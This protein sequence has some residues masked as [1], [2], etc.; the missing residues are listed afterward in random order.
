MNTFNYFY[1]SAITS[2]SSSSGST[3]LT[4]LDIMIQNYWI[5]VN[6]LEYME[7]ILDKVKLDC[8]LVYFKHEK[9]YGVKGYP[10]TK[11]SKKFYVLLPPLRFHRI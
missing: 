2:S 1:I 9:G 6:K 5:D 7:Y 4:P 3:N 10:T 11:V 8:D